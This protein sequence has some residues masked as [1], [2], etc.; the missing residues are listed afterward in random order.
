MRLQWKRVGQ[1]AGIT[2]PAGPTIGRHAAI[3]AVL[4]VRRASE[5][6]AKR[7]PQFAL[8]AAASAQAPLVVDR[9]GLIRALVGNVGRA[10]SAPSTGAGIGQALTVFRGA[11]QLAEFLPSSWVFE[12]SR[13][14][15]ILVAPNIWETASKYR[16][17]QDDY[18]RLVAA[19]A[20]LWDSLF[21]ASP[22]LADRIFVHLV[23]QPEGRDDAVRA[24]V[25]FNQ[26][27]DDQL[28]EFT[29]RTIP[30]I[31][32]LR[33]KD[34]CPFGRMLM[35]ITGISESELDQVAV[36]TRSFADE[37]DL[38][39]HP[40]ALWAL[41]QDFTN[42]PTESELEEPSLWRGRLGYA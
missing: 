31:N 41:L 26:L 9:V 19:R 10:Q 4:R 30:S 29:P 2:T 12:G 37:V 39:G 24:A 16:L 14:R 40:R 34:P 21:A 11:R 22:W 15:P 18:A 42:L 35:G 5:W 6:A 25:L 1:L 7:T 3:A 33:D 20:L 27:V 8:L 36:Q 17:D 13:A 28:A 32:W 23:S 38:A